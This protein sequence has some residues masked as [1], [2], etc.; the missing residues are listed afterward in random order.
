M[1]FSVHEEPGDAVV[2][3]I[4]YC[5]SRVITQSG[6]IDSRSAVRQ[7]IFMC[8]VS[9]AENIGAHHS[10]PVSPLSSVADWFK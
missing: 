6:R 4:G 8:V 3:A 5:R 7:I 2:V 1:L 10:S 9:R